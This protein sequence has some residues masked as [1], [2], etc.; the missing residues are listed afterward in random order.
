M[1]DGPTGKEV[2]R[3]K[4]QRLR[5]SEL[6]AADE[7]LGASELA[8]LLPADALAAVLDGATLRRFEQGTVVF[9]EGD[10][11]S[12]LFFILRGEAQL[13]CESAQ[14]AL[15]LRGE[16]FGE[17]EVIRP[18]P[19]CLSAHAAAELEVAEI[20][21]EA[22]TALGAAARPLG[23]RLWEIAQA[24]QGARSELDAFLKRW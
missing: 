1:Q 17:A 9:R 24:R 10:P 23:L 11:G 18:A 22:F 7:V 2:S 14:V 15:C 3:V 20:Q 19:R 13:S 4:L 5:L 8:T 21:R 12:T 16:V 6:V